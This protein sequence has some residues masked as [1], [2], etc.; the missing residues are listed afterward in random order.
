MNVKQDSKNIPVEAEGFDITVELKFPDNNPENL[1]DFGSVRVGDFAD[2][3]F[4]VKNTG[5]YKVKFSF[6][7]KKRS[8]KE[9]FRVEP[10]EVEL[11]P[12]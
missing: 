7:L 10:M 12:T 9:M 6:V 11:D 8:T 2:R 4:I 1:L 3:T 5:L